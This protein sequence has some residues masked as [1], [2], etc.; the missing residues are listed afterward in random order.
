MIEQT[1]PSLSKYSTTSN[2]YLRYAF[3][4]RKDAE[5]PESPTFKEEP[6]PHT[7]AL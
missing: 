3:T 5:P 1:N 2:I 4:F 7:Q 6:V